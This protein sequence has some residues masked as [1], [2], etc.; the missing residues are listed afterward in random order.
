MLTD[1]LAWDRFDLVGHD[2]GG[3]IG[4]WTAARHAG[5]LRTLTAVSTPHPSALAEAHRIDARLYRPGRP[6]NRGPLRLLARP[7]GAA[8]CR[9]HQ[10]RVP[11]GRPAPSHAGE[12]AVGLR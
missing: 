8:L 9:R 11:R 2:W 5:R 7:A 3:A 12:R 10:D 1:T 6:D 4:W